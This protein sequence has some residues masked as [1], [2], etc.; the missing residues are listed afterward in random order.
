MPR[1]F[2]RACKP[3]RGAA[4]FTGDF[5]MFDVEASYYA[6]AK[7][8]GMRIPTGYDDLRPAFTAARQALA[9]RA[10]GD[11]PC[12]ND[13]LAAHFIADGDPVWLTTYKYT[14]NTAP[15]LNPRHT[16]GQIRP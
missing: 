15:P 7:S 8:A 4:R 9:A 13:L 2:A 10:E 6:T 16:P 1:R 11:V 3:L 5:G 12:N 14:A